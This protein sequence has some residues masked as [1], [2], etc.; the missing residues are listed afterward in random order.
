MMSNAT[1]LKIRDIRDDI[2]LYNGGKTLLVFLFFVGVGI[3][4]DVNGIYFCGSC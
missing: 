2:F 1:R 3:Y 4:L